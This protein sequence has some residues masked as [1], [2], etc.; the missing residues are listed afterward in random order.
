M[1]V[2]WV[3]RGIA[4]AAREGE[5]QQQPAELKFRVGISSSRRKVS[6]RGAQEDA[7]RKA[8]AQDA[9]LI[10]GPVNPPPCG[11][12]AAG[13]RGEADWP[14]DSRTH[15]FCRGSKP[16]ESFTSLGVI[17]LTRVTGPRSRG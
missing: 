17:H 11:M 6:T 10:L 9:F 15:V 13:S 2:R 16:L 4:Q 1:L 5:K 14:S 7:S 12:A 8:C 3:R